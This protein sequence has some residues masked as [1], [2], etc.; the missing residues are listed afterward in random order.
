MIELH[1]FPTDYGLPNFSPFCMKVECFLKMA[2]LKYNIV[3]IAVPNKGPKK[4]APFIDDGDVRMG[5]SEL[6]I[7]YLQKKHGIDINQSLNPEE[8]AISHS[9]QKMLDE[10]FYWILVHSRWIDDRGFAVVRP[11]F[12]GG[13]PP[14]VRSIA[15]IIGR[16]SVRKALWQAG[17]GRHTPDEIYAF[18]KA[19]IQAVADLLGDK[20][21]MHGPEPTLLDACVVSYTGSVLLP[22]IETPLKEAVK[23]HA[24]LVAF[25]ER[26]MQRY[27]PG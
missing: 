1:Q 6:I 4:K 7:Q 9:T 12:F 24:N 25:N 19:D 5:D 2:E 11:L 10:H 15:P 3:E 27:F 14:M 23:S 13:L 22:P 16:S 26:M 20:L 18:G 17:M 8:R 21:Y